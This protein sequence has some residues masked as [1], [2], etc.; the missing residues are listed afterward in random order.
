M[1]HA[2]LH[3]HALREWED[4]SVSWLDEMYDFAARFPNQVGFRVKDLT[5][6]PIAKRNPKDPLVAQINV[7][8]LAKTNQD[9]LVAQLVKSLNGDEHLKASQ[10]KLNNLG[11]GNQEIQLKVDIA[12][13]AADRYQTRIAPP[14]QLTADPT[15]QS[16]DEPA[17]EPGGDGEEK[18]GAR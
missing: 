8:I 18:G 4:T 6:V 2:P 14:P 17:E 9:A 10:G 15:P 7:T 11:T 16:I 13:Q 3:V 5:A 1:T 12:K